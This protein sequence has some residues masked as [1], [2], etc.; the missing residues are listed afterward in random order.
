[1]SGPTAAAWWGLP[2]FDVREIHVSRRRRP[3]LPHAT[4]ANVVHDVVSLPPQQVTMHQG[5]P[6]VRPERLAVELFGLLS[7]GRAGRAVENAWSRRLLDGA[8]VRRAAAELGK[9]RRGAA[10][11]R[12]FLAARPEGWVPP[13]SG[14]EARFESLMRRYSL[15]VWRRQVDLGGE[16]GW[17][18]RVDFLCRDLPVVVEVQ[19]ELYHA[20]LA[21]READARR[22][23]RLR[24]DGFVVL[25]AWEHELWHDPDR[26]ADDVLRAFAAARLRRPRRELV[27]ASRD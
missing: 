21:D 4:L 7:P 14:L 2:G 26:V 20:A 24:A 9:A 15:G 10:A 19:S 1:V 18:G 23:D 13:Q 12:E 27:A 11:L 16:Q 17:T 5:I 8:G 25:E 6:V 22:H 3:S